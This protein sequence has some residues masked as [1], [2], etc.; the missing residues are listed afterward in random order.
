MKINQTACLTLIL[1]LLLCTAAAA[2]TV[3]M[4]GVAK[5]L[6]TETILAPIGGT[7]RTVDV[8]EGDTVNAGAPLLTLKT[9]VVYADD[10]GRVAFY[11]RPGERA[12]A[13]EDLYGAVAVIDPDSQYMISTTTNNAYD[14]NENKMVRS[15]IQVFLQ[16]TDDSKKKSG[17]GQVYDVEGK[18]FKVR[19]LEGNFELGDTVNIYQSPT[20]DYRTRIGRGDVERTDSIRYSGEGSIVSLL[21][22][23]GAHVEKGDPLFETLEGTFDGLISTGNSITA[24]MNGVVSEIAVAQ[25]D[26]I[27]NHQVVAQIWPM[28]SMR[29]M[30]NVQEMDLADVEV[31]DPVEIE[32]DAFP[33]QWIKGTIEKIGFSAISD[34]D[35]GKNAEYEAVISFE[36]DLQIR[37]GMHAQVRTGAK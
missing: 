25:G 13:V 32:F 31:G 5:A 34:D 33:G 29:V 4:D 12:E 19:V 23:N 24:P 10:P 3:Y 21:A 20:F 9:T 28:E 35:A 18:K 16:K 8:R 7:V 36:T 22:E 30:A 37:F 6:S 2:D 15:G 17:I 14:T 26:H 27:E 1:V 11:G